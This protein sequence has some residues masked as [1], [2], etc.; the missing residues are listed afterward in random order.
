V[1][2]NWVSRDDRRLI[3]V[4]LSGGAVQG[5]VHVPWDDL[6]EATWRLTDT[7]SG[8]TYDR[9]GKEIQADGLY[10]ELE[11]WGRHVLRCHAP[12]ATPAE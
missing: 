1:A 2:W 5:R 4:N 6:R 9:A 11:P 8:A 3:V 12:I 7:M 10:V